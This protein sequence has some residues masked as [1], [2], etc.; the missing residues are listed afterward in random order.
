MK[1]TVT[2]STP[3]KPALRGFTLIELMVAVVIVGILAAVAYPSYQS[4]V[5][6]SRRTDARNAALDL[7]ARQERYFS[8]YNS[9]SSSVTGTGVNGLGYSSATI[10]VGGSAWYTASLPVAT[11]TTY[12]IKLTPIAGTDQ[13]NDPCYAFMVDHLGQTSNVDASS[14]AI[15]ASVGCW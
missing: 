11:S 10:T 12:T 9:Y 4:Q 3:S 7:A 14:K 8:Q 13:V 2:R 6:K 15:A 1:S 5:R